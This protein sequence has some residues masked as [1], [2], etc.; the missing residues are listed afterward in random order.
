MSDIL[1]MLAKKKEEAGEQKTKSVEEEAI[2][3]LLKEKVAAIT[4][5]KKRQAFDS[6]ISKFAS[7]DQTAKQLIEAGYG[8]TISEK[9]P[10]IFD[11]Q[12][13]IKMRK[14]F[15]NR[16]Q[17]LL[18]REQIEAEAKRLK[19][20]VAEKPA[21]SSEQAMGSDR[22]VRT[23]SNQNNQADLSDGQNDAAHLT[24]K[25]FREEL[26]KAGV[27]EEKITLAYMVSGANWNI[28]DKK[29]K[30]K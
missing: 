17:E 27:P 12:D 14:V 19:S 24:D 6:E 15:L 25:A 29:L 18:E 7:E 26:R 30:N 13:P 2:E 4:E 11:V 22:P 3:S 9:Y 1:A 21:G 28:L 5:Q 20:A 8:K 16:A 10:E 23:R